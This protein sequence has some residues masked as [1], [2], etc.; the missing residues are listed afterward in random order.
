MTARH[1]SPLEA[2]LVDDAFDGDVYPSE[3]MARHTMY[4]IGGPARFYVQVASVGALKR[5]VTV[6]EESRVPW[7]AIGRGSNLLVADEGYPGVVITLG[8][9]FRICRYD[10]DAHSFCVGA[11]VPLSSVRV[12]DLD[13]AERSSRAQKTYRRYLVRIGIVAALVLALVGGGLAVYYSNLFTI[14]N[15]SVTGVEH[16]TATDMSELASVPAGTTLLRVDAAGIRERLLKDAWVDD[17]S[18]NRVFPN[19]LELAVTERTITAV[20]DVPT[21]NA[22]S[23]QPW[24]IASDGMWLM[25]IPDQNSEAGKRTSPKVYEDAAK[26][27]HITDVPYGTRPEVGAYCS[28]ANVN[29]ALAIVDGMTTELAGQVK[30]VAAT[31]TESTTLTLESGV[32]IVFGTAENIRDKERVCLE[33]MKEH[34]DGLAYINVR[35]VDRP[36]WRAL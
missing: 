4:R 33:I 19:T 31:E 28:D 13:R 29:N 3:P 36:T 17:V 30:K 8:R 21:E 2:L 11:G 5:L 27:L 12:G 1:T 23:V 34:P 7:V 9:D 16:L 18:V 14:E 24:A 26:V 35:V 20:V 6:C 15:V 22:E 25:P 32:E 10:E